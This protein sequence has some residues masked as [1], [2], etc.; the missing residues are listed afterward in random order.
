MELSTWT[1]KFGT[2][3]TWQ[4]KSGFTPIRPQLPSI[5]ADSKTQ[6]SRAIPNEV[7]EQYQ[8]D[9]LYDF[10]TQELVDLDVVSSRKLKASNL[11]GEIIPFL[12]QNRW[13]DGNRVAGETVR[14]YPFREDPKQRWLGINPNVWKI[15]K[16]SLLIATRMFTSPGVQ[17]FVS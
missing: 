1:K 7:I 8:R 17:V 13:Y 10:T 6:D 11:G 3:E 2:H 16:P 4:N 14:T 5:A 15:L 12:R 9:Q